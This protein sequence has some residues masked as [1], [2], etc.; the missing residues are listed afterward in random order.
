MSGET[1]TI[2]VISFLP[3]STHDAVIASKTNIKLENI[4]LKTL[5]IISFHI[6]SEINKKVV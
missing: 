4:S 6:H 2:G 5:I 3:E 1:V